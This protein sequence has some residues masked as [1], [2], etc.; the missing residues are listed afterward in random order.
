MGWFN[1]LFLSVFILNATPVESIS[2]QNLIEWKSY[3][4]GMDAAK[5]NNRLVFLHFYAK[6]CGYCAKMEKESFQDDS[7]A[8]YLNDNFISIRV[9]VDEEQ[10]IAEVYNVYALP[11][12]YFF[13]SSG[14]KLGPVPGYISK[15]RLLT[16]LK[17]V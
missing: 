1:I 16:M 7:I 17:K 3:A 15:D 2:S 10:S 6:W 4:M 12:T 9:D 11:T 14:E 8:E 5:N 13:T